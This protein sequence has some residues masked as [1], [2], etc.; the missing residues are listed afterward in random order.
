MQRLFK[1]LSLPSRIALIVCAAA[2]V[3]CLIMMAVTP[4]RSA[5]VYQSNEYEAEIQQTH[6]GVALTENGKEVSGDNDLLKD[7]VYLLGGDDTL[8]PGKTYPEALAVKNISSDMDEYVRLTVRKYWAIGEKQDA[9]G[10]DARV[11]SALRD[12][13]FI[14][15]EFD[16]NSTGSW[17]YSEEESTPERLVFYYK[18][19]L[20]A[21]HSSEPA[22]TGI[23]VSEQITKNVKEDYSKCWL[24]ISAQVDSVQVN[25]AADAAKSAWGVDI[26]DLGL[27][28]SAGMTDE[29]TPAGE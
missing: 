26:A 9:Q 22:V 23:R 18:D 27:D 4:A 11:K 10:N 21:G 13:S 24:A 15:L 5:L 1:N 14:E 3:G 19:V 20:K 17:V 29:P 28:W 7:Q 12:P 2:L 6:I 16:E 25:N 8:K